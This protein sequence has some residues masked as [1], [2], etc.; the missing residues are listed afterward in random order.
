VAGD[1]VPHRPSADLLARFAC[2][3]ARLLRGSL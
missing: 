2:S 1:S 3:V